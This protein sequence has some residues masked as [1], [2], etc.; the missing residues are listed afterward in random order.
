MTA[1]EVIQLVPSGVDPVEIVS[2]MEFVFGNPACLELGSADLIHWTALPIIQA[3]MVE[4][5][6]LQTP[7]VM[8]IWGDGDKWMVA[9]VRVN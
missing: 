6:L 5:E 9:W 4:N 1:A 8:A 7:G 3:R 2:D